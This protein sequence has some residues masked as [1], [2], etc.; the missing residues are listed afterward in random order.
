MKILKTASGQQKIK[1]SRKEWEY[2]GTKANWLKT[3]HMAR[4]WIN[5]ILTQPNLKDQLENAFNKYLDVE[6]K[7]KQYKIE[8]FSPNSPTIKPYELKKQEL[9][10]LQSDLQSEWQNVLSIIEKNKL[11]DNYGSGKTVPTPDDLKSLF[12]HNLIL[13]V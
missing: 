5:Q 10:K 3:A 11:A 1:M 8:Q 4:H 12:A 2:I 7:L 9:D 6:N 13:P